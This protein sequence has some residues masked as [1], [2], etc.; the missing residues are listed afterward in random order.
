M[1]RKTR[2]ASTDNATL[3][4]LTSS[5]PRKRRR[6]APLTNAERQ[7]RFRRKR[8]GVV[9]RQD[10]TPSERHKITSKTW[11]I[12][13]PDDMK[14][15]SFFREAKTLKI[16]KKEATENYFPGEKPLTV[17]APTLN[18][19]AEFQGAL[20]KLLA[21]M[22]STDARVVKPED[23]SF[24][25]DFNGA[26]NPQIVQHQ[27]Y[28]PPTDFNRWDGYHQDEE[29]RTP[30]SHQLYALSLVLATRSSVFQLTNAL[31]IY[32]L[33][34]QK[35]RLQT[36]TYKGKVGQLIV[37]QGRYMH[38]GHILKQGGCRQIYTNCFRIA[39]TTSAKNHRF[40]LWQ[41]KEAEKKQ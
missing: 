35:F 40:R 14:R 19:H 38:R 6:T 3:R 37:F 8:E 39:D 24:G 29:S 25:D 15:S 1:A 2:N 34:D 36:K 11:V 10:I 5:K 16:P 27:G 7:L 12:D 32:A 17:D 30:N 4:R 28:V 13:I 9:R 26:E 21:E 22:M 31:D 33:K 20:S 41:I 23:I 18:G